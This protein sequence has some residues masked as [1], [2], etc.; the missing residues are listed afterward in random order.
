MDESLTL[1]HFFANHPKDIARSPVPDEGVLVDIDDRA[2][3]ERELRR[4]G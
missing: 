4:N 1:K 3:Y 2:T